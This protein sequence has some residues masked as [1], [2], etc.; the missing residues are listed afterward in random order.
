MAL[1]Y[2]FSKVFELI[3]LDRIEDY[4][5][6]TDNQ[7][8]LK[9]GMSNGVK[10]GGM[11][12]PLFFNVYMND[13]IVWLNESNVSG[14]LQDQRLNHLCYADDLTLIS[15]CSTD[16]QTL[17]QLCDKYAVEHEIILKSKKS[18]WMAFRPHGVIFDNPHLKLKVSLLFFYDHSIYVGTQIELKGNTMDINWQ[19]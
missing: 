6:T 11:L 16:M 9:E 15:I 10:Q 3:L 12:S 5:G 17:L 7:F 2:V 18:Q 1:A 8:C 19:L 13:L 4:L 14:Y